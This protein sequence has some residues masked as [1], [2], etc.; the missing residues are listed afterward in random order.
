MTS[1]R[2]MTR[3]LLVLLTAGALVAC[4]GETA[5][6]TTAGAAGAEWI[7]QFTGPFTRGP[8]VDGSQVWV[9]TGERTVYVQDCEV[10]ERLTQEGAQYGPKSRDVDPSGRA[11]FAHVCDDTYSP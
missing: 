10:G 7:D 11:G 3:L 8:V 9:L 5:S 6:T 4:S 2:P 1:V